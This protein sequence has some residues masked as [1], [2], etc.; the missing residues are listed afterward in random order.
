MAGRPKLRAKLEAEAK[1]A[2][3]SYEAYKAKV[4]A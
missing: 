3:L 4:E 1:E 2:G